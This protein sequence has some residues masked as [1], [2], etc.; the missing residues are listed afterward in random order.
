MLH[1]NTRKVL[2]IL[3][4]MRS[5][6]V[7][8]VSASSHLDII[9][10]T[11]KI[12]TNPGI[13][14]N[15]P[16]KFNNVPLTFCS[17]ISKWYKNIYTSFAPWIIFNTQAQIVYACAGDSFS[18]MR[19]GHWLPWHEKFL[20]SSIEEMLEKYP[21]PKKFHIDF[22]NFFKTLDPQEVYPDLS[23]Q[24]ARTTYRLDEC[25]RSDYS[26][27]NW[28]NEIAFKKPTEIYDIQVFVWKEELLKILSK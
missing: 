6:L 14:I 19:S 20:C 3:L 18:L 24:Q 10:K 28:C 5:S 22:I 23:P 4:Q 16:P 17:Y 21:T 11:N 15:Q 27:R 12:G 1:N 8:T 2:F 7:Q 13:L 26:K 25:F 9:K